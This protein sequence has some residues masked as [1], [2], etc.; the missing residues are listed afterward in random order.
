MGITFHLFIMQHFFK[1]QIS[2]QIIC[3]QFFSQIIPNLKSFFTV[4]TFTYIKTTLTSIYEPWTFQK[5]I[6][7]HYERSWS[8]T[9]FR[10]TYLIWDF[11]C[12]QPTDPFALCFPPWFLISALLP[13]FVHVKNY[14][15]HTLTS[16]EEMHVCLPCKV[17]LKDCSKGL[18]ALLMLNLNN[19]LVPLLPQYFKL[20]QQT[21]SLYVR[22]SSSSTSA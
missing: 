2:F 11:K 16:L 5:H 12:W 14:F 1:Q 19:L 7:W 8:Q 21:W 17:Y 18:L 13:R 10:F 9:C 20:Q 4:Q 3:Y 6:M 15:F 22:L